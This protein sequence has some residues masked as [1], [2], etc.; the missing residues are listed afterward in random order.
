[1][2][3]IN[4]L[5]SSV[6][7]HTYTEKIRDS[8]YIEGNIQVVPKETHLIK[9]ICE[10]FISQNELEYK[11]TEDKHT[12]SSLKKLDIANKELFESTV[13]VRTFP[14][15]MIQESLQKHNMFSSV[16]YLNETYNVCCV[17]HN[18]DTGNYYRTCVK[19]FPMFVCVYE[20][21]AWWVS[22]DPVPED[23]IFSDIMDLDNILMMDIKTTMIYK[24]DLLPISKYKLSDLEAMAHDRSIS[25]SMDG[26][27]KLK[28]QLYEDINLKY[29]Q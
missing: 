25:L 15:K 7:M 6:K 19:P 23:V 24:T 16:L 4:K 8:K 5:N 22:E 28:K 27:K 11:V 12:F 20:N 21:E 9:D 14:Y 29:F 13:Y 2:E 3:I 18:V 1:M 26:R 10:C 17:I